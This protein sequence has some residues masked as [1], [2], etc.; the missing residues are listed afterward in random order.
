MWILSVKKVIVKSPWIAISLDIS[1]YL[2]FQIN[3]IYSL[4]PSNIVLNLEMCG[5]IWVNQWIFETVGREPQSYF[6]F[7]HFPQ[8]I[9]MWMFLPYCPKL[10]VHMIEIFFSITTGGTLL[11]PY[12]HWWKFVMTF[13]Y[14]NCCT[15]SNW[16]CE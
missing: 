4:T 12:Y 1:K 6:W 10:S 15:E 9:N 7:M 8:S 14:Y 13:N 16:N 3:I 11:F 5:Y 2:L